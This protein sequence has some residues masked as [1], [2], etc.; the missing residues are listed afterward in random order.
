MRR[1]RYRYDIHC[2]HCWKFC[3]PFDSYTYYGSVTDEE[4]PDAEFLC[5]S[6]FWRAVWRMV[7]HPWKNGPYWH[8]PWAW[9]VASSIRRHERK[10]A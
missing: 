8:R 6:C 9:T 4:P 5:E 3:K 7:K 10:A 1:A 2:G